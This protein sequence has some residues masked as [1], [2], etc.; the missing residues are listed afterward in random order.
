MFRDSGSFQG[1]NSF[2]A[3]AHF[4]D[5]VIPRPLSRPHNEVSVVFGLGFFPEAKKINTDLARLGREKRLLQAVKLLQTWREEH[6]KEEVY[7]VLF[8]NKQKLR[9]CR[10]RFL[11]GEPGFIAEVRGYENPVDQYLNKFHNIFPELQLT[12]REEIRK[13][14]VLR[15]YYYLVP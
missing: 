9:L 3:G 11:D 4:E 7:F 10:G 2:G 1:M 15:W 12:V 13:G 14:E 5:E 8:P 6:R